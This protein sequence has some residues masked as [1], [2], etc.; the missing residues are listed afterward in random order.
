MW[1]IPILPPPKH[2]SSGVRACMCAIPGGF[3]RGL[4]ARLQCLSKYLWVTFLH[5]AEGK[6]APSLPETRNGP[7]GA[8][9][10][11]NLVAPTSLTAQ[12][13]RGG[14]GGG[15]GAPRARD[16]G[17]PAPLG[18]LHAACAGGGEIKGKKGHCLPPLLRVLHPAPPYLRTW[19]SRGRPRRARPARPPARV[20]PRPPPSSRRRRGGGG[21][22]AEAAVKEKGPGH[23]GSWSPPFKDPEKRAKPARH[24]VAARASRLPHPAGLR[25]RAQHGRG[26]HA[27]HKGGGHARGNVGGCKARLE[28]VAM[29]RGGSCPADYTPQFA[30][31]CLRMRSAHT[32][33][34]PGLAARCGAKNHPLPLS[35]PPPRHVRAATPGSGSSASTSAGAGRAGSR[36]T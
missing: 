15:R 1:M 5:Y 4:S 26:G 24:R 35:S 31:R 10:L 17:L 3:P 8:G 12:N 21:A 28:G 30:P 27:Q 25:R 11:P 2:T 29:Q 7:S 13:N 36:V 19:R 20:L 32:P 22:G 9:L 33:P 18:L 14:C 23:C 16:P 34:C 6:A